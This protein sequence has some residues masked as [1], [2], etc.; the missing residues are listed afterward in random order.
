MS[1]NSR[2]NIWV[3]HTDGGFT[4]KQEGNSTPLVPT[5]TQQRA[6][7]VARNIARQNQSELFIQGRDGKIR[8]RDS[9]GQDPF[10][11]RDTKH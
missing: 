4:V 3:V 11:P 9:F 5:T 8:D 1:K 10:P 6:T 7:E 2:P